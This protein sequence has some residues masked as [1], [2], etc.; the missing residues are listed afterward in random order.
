MQA[1][2]TFRGV[3]LVQ[4][5]SSRTAVHFAERVLQQ[6]KHIRNLDISLETPKV[7]LAKEELVNST[8]GRQQASSKLLTRQILVI[9][10][11]ATLE[12]SGKTCE[13]KN[14]P[15]IV[16][17]TSSQRH[18]NDQGSRQDSEVDLSATDPITWVKG[19]A[20]LLC[21][22]LNLQAEGEALINALRRTTD[23]VELIGSNMTPITRGGLTSIDAFCDEVLDQY[24]RFLE[25]VNS[26][27]RANAISSEPVA[28]PL[29]PH[30]PLSLVE[31]I[32]THHAV[33]LE[34]PEVC[35][36]DMICVSVDWTLTSELL[37]AGMDKTYTAMNRPRLHRNDR[38]WLAVDHTV[39]PRTNHQSRQRGLIDKAERFRDEAKIIDF[40]PAN[41]SIM[42][43][44]FTRDRAQ[45]GYL[46]IGSDSHTC[47]AGSMGAFAVGFGA[48]DVVM[49]LVTGETWFR[50][51]EVCRINFVGKLPYG[52]SGKDVI[53]YILGQFKR[54]TIAFQR[55]V[56]YG[57][58]GLI[59]L[60]MD[61][62]FAIANM[63]TEFGG[64]G[65]CFE[66]DERTAAWL[67]SRRL[68][69][70]KN[71]P[72]YFKPDPDARYAETRTIDLSEVQ[73][74]VALYPNPDD[75]VPIDRKAG[76]K[77]DGC[78]IG[79]CTTTEEELILA[80][81]VLEVGL[82][83]GLRPTSRGKR[84]V[85]PGS[86][87][88]T[89]KLETLGLTEVYKQAGFEI[90]APSCSYCVGINDVDVAQP[91]EVWLSSQNRNFRNRMGPGSIGNVTSA[92][93]V[94]ASSF[95]MEVRNPGPLLAMIDTKRYQSLFG[96]AQ[97]VPKL[98]PQYR[99]PASRRQSPLATTNSKNIPATT[100][101]RLGDDLIK[102][103][104]QRFGTNVDTDAIIP[105][106]FMP[107]INDADLGSH[108]FEHVRPDFRN[109]V[110]NGATV[111]V[112]EHGFGSGSS[113]E[114]A[115]RA[116]KGSGVQMIIA[117]S[118]AFIYER[119]QLNMGLFNARISD[120]D[121]YQH[122]NEG[123]V[124]TVD[125][126]ARTLRIAGADKTWKYEHTAIEAELLGAGGVLSLYHLYGNSLFRELTRSRQI[127][128]YHS[129]TIKDF[130][131]VELSRKPQAALAW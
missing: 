14:Q 86:L 82:A 43:T 30:R 74:T 25:A 79:A 81:L 71:R 120:D 67:A 68:P 87:T 91:G 33:G 97:A 27:L 117:K 89:R 83:T 88:I 69:K 72:L 19:L 123:A 92:A 73:A 125:K 36:G 37:W 48:A 46:V 108:C 8:G 102:G 7:P 121:F 61:A 3:V 78:F 42:H 75:V 16:L 64:M 101:V 95:D 111:V 18:I 96:K 116:L 1:A 124:L 53:L 39:D 57:G 63:T 126:A 55:A 56:E 49:P 24:S 104:V 12:T 38:V 2:P 131:S 76:M 29:Y 17:G 109:K 107:G 15:L 22:V 34:K 122:A 119:N 20:T 99:E 118:F 13:I 114:D 110:A 5:H 28:K 10:Q 70:D 128:E 80:G 31:K 130:T 103:M 65:A 4:G 59:E 84:R 127:P 54:N 41:T 11:N 85:T 6:I 60:S 35:P 44:D 98:S 90:G 106:Q 45:P 26:S 40:L 47:S 21:G 23:P 115:V 9:D 50:V 113:R 66:S 93:A 77:L 52:I 129:R 100:S 94:A 62:R 51:P 112:A 58:P 105:A 32:L